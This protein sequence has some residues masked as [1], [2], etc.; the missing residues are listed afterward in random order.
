MLGG[1]SLMPAFIGPHRAGTAYALE[2]EATGHAR[3]GNEWPMSAYPHIR[4]EASCTHSG[5]SSWGFRVTCTGCGAVEA[6]VGGSSVSAE[7]AP[8]RFAWNHRECGPS[9]AY[10][11]SYG[12]IID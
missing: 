4:H 12:R 10:V 3:F 9:T 2:R 6:C 5:R 1:A 8:R 11:D 7:D